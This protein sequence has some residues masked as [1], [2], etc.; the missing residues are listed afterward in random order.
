M[1]QRVFA[2][3]SDL[4][5][6][7][8]HL[9]LTE[10]AARAL[11]RRASIVI[12]GLTVAARYDVDE[13][14]YPADLDV[15]EALRD[16]TCAQAVWFDETGDASGAEGRWQ[17][18]SLGT[19]ALTRTGAG[20]SAGTASVAESRISPEATTILATAGLLGGAPSSW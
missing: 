17:S 16:A 7:P 1:A 13:D 9:A 11:L 3:P 12:E 4:A 19:A 18:L 15:T 6:E 14:G 10:P 5:G 8:W 2:E 20:T